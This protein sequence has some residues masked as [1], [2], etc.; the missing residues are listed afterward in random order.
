LFL[1]LL[2]VLACVEKNK[3]KVPSP[4]DLPVTDL[5]GDQLAKI[6]CATCHSFV[7][8]D[9]LPKGIW[10]NDVLPAMGH[11]LGIFNGGH[12]PDSIFGSARNAVFVKKANIFPD[13]PTISRADWEKITAYY[14]KNSP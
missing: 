1:L 14:D 11:R 10:K 12:R 9:M 8:P 2:S 4:T 6:I 13:R 5:R 7:P 3:V